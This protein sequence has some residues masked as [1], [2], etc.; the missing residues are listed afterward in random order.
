MRSPSAPKCCWPR[1]SERAVLAGPRIY[2]RLGHGFSNATSLHPGPK[3]KRSLAAAIAASFSRLGTGCPIGAVVKAR[4]SRITAG[5]TRVSVRLP[6][7][8]KPTTC[9]KKHA[10]TP[11]RRQHAS[12]GEESLAK[13]VRVSLR[14]DAELL[15][16]VSELAKRQGITR[17]SWLHRAA[18]DA[19]SDSRMGGA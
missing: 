5:A 1:H 3:M 7:A 10:S 9:G 8:P 11:R 14:F 6:D 13:K 16:R 18:F 2:S 19:L 4:S 12:A 17:T 15:A